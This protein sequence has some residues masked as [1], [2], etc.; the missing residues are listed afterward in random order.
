MDI[1]SLYQSKLTTPEEAVSRIP[2]GSRMS[3]GMAV[4]EPPALLKALA[5]R[6]EAGQ[7]GDLRV[8]YFEGTPIAGD[9][10]F[11]YELADRIR[12]FSMFITASERAL[13]KQGMKD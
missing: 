9:T 8:Y 1:A 3:M 11:R 7:V 4:A 2:S 5:A 12:P 10:I 13:I 6:A